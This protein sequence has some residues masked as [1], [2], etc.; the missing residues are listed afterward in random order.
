MGKRYSTAKEKKSYNRNRV[1]KTTIY[2]EIPLK[3]T[4]TY[5]Y[6]KQ[7]DRLDILAYRYYGSVEDWWI[8]ARAN[9]LGKG[10][11]YVT[12]GLQLRIPANKGELYKEL[13]KL[14]KRR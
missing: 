9:E 2:P 1:F 11:L 10:T 6:V 5:I 7:G 4:D 13:E 14:N 8:L 3:E 12:P